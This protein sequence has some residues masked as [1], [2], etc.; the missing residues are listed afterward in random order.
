MQ[1]LSNFDKNLGLERIPIPRQSPLL[2]HAEEM[3]DMNM[4]QQF[5]VETA[6]YDLKQERDRTYC[7]ECTL[8]GGS[9]QTMQVTIT[10]CKYARLLAEESFAFVD[11]VKCSIER[12]SG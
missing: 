6:L 4:L 9:S 8:S 1:N 12:T 3:L 10:G 7:E 5:K 11:A 2:H